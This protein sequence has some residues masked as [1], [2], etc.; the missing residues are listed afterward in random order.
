MTKAAAGVWEIDRVDAPPGTCYRYEITSAGGEVHLR[1][2]PLARRAALRPSACSI[3]E[4]SRHEW[5][6][7]DW[8]AARAGSDL[9]SAPLSIYEVHLG[10]WRR[11][12]DDPGRQLPWSELAAPLADHAS[13]LGFTHVELLPV[14][15]H[16]Y[17][18][19]WGYLSTGYFA[20]DPRHGAPDELRALIDHLHQ[21][22]LG[23]ILD[24]VP[25]HFSADDWALADFDG[26][27]TYEP[28][29]PRRSIQPQWGAHV[30]DHSRP[31]VRS[32][33]L[34]SALYWLNEF[35]ADGLR[36]DSVAAM[37]RHDWGRDGYE[38][39]ANPDG[40]LE[41]REAVEF[42]QEL[43]ALVATEAPGAITVA[44]EASGAPGVTNE[45]GL[46]FTFAWN[47]G[48]AHDWLSY[49]ERAPDERTAIHNDITFASSYADAANWVLAL[50]HDDVAECSLIARMWG[51]DAVASAQL[52]ALLA[53]Q[54]AHRGKKLLFMGGEFAQPGVWSHHG[55]LEWDRADPRMQEFVAELGRIYKQRSALWAR[56]DRDDGM[57]W[58][59]ADERETS[60]YA[61]ARHGDDGDLL[62]CAANLSAMRRVVDL[63][64]P[65]LA[66]RGWQVT[67]DS[68]D[69]PA[70]L[71]CG[72]D[73]VSL[74]LPAFSCVWISPA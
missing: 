5:G 58:L 50:S 67:L 42:L 8:M 51:D 70:V 31:E 12:E 74:S 30:F 40:S 25:G 61:F 37:L 56:D 22:G 35:H 28:A 29:D 26:G 71:T 2:D 17:P 63:E 1:S 60:T 49:F 6:D 62:V 39:L 64:S 47:M 41:N 59:L 19:S 73:L 18:G 11:N 46:G 15:A 27:P 36:I 55:Q 21:R 44:E 4:R 16:P 7:A 43:T 33:L 45:D 69:E 54:W 65:L 13:A 20:P 48:W 52:R 24:W 3:V 14:T 32:F 23:V 66:G 38:V 10:S 9:R 34:S 68:G 53:L 72:D 57:S